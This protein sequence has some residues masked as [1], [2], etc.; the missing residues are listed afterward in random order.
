MRGVYRAVGVA[1]VSVGMLGYFQ[2]PVLGLFTSNPYH[3]LLHIGSG[4]AMVIAARHGILS[5][6]RWGML[7]G[8]LYSALAIAGF[9][10]R[11]GDFFGLMHLDRPDNLLHVGLAV[12]YL[13]Y[14]W[15]APPR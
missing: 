2:N 5:M 7:L 8:L 1:L 12:I 4:L 11:R 14:A 13:Y 15:L 10:L 3:N 9:T 6:R